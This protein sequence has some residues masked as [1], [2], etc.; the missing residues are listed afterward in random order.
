MTKQVTW[1]IPK[2]YTTSAGVDKYR[3]DLR[4]IGSGQRF[5][6]RTSAGYKAARALC[7]SVAEMETKFGTSMKLLTIDQFAD[8]C[9]AV[10]I[11]G[12]SDITLEDIAEDWKKVNGGLVEVAFCY[13][14]DLY[15]EWMRCCTGKTFRESTI[16]G[17]RSK[18]GK[19]VA[20][21][22]KK[23]THE[24]TREDILALFEANEYT[25]N[26]QR[27]Y[28]MELKLF[29]DWCMIQDYIGHNPMLS[30][31]KP[32]KVYQ[33]IVILK[34]PSM[35]QKLLEIA[36]RDY[37]DMVVPIALKFFA[38][39]RSNELAQINCDDIDIS[40]G[41]IHICSSVSKTKRERY[42]PIEAN[43]RYILERHMEETFPWSSHKWQK[44]CALAGYEATDNVGRKSY[45]SY[46]SRNWKDMNLT[47]ENAGNSIGVALT[48]YQ[49][50]VTDK[51]AK[52]YWEIIV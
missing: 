21:F 28:W 13:A 10:K 14:A 32:G 46:H 33:D 22:P 40:A 7:A 2:E 29:F 11:L 52:D 19:L 50:L 9:R 6:P 27:G 36:D 48:H 20:M 34:P 3:V 26:T 8:A 5:F 30:I 42:V 41:Y 4:K 44:I 51:M 47:T 15:I 24:V 39:L 37:H 17:A 49:A 18:V 43:L 1:P 16:T 45:I 25:Q 12:N 31:D 35:L 38:G 23:N